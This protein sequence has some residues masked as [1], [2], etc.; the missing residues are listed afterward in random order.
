MH[1]H[2][3]DWL[4]IKGVRVDLP[5][6]RGQI[7]AVGSPEGSP[8]F[9]VHWLADDRISTVFPGPDSVVLTGAELAA[10]DEA[11]RTRFERS[12]ALRHDGKGT[13]RART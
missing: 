1:A 11:D 13:F 7:V 5:E 6:Q 4:V 12:S 2:P 8:P 10:R 9:T 3:G